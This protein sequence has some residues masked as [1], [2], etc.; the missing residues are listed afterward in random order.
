M[1]PRTDDTDAKHVRCG[2]SHL[3]LRVGGAGGKTRLSSMLRVVHRVSHFA[4][5]FYPQPV[6]HVCPVRVGVANYSY[7]VIH[8]FSHRRRTAG[9]GTSHRSVHRCVHRPVC[10]CGG[11]GFIVIPGHPDTSEA[12]TVTQHPPMQK[13]LLAFWRWLDRNVLRHPTWSLVVS[14]LVLIAFAYLGLHA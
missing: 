2:Q 5:F 14:G 11:S 6:D 3:G 13:H 9:P 8:S 1:V 10:R 7:V 12:T 4:I